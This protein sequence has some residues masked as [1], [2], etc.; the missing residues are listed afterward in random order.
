ME[1][2]DILAGQ[3]G[4]YLLI[5]KLLLQALCIRC[6]GHAFLS[7]DRRHKIIG[8]NVK[9]I[10]RNADAQRELVRNLNLG[11]YNC[12]EFQECIKQPINLRLN[13]LT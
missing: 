12:P 3:T 9:R 10:V 7:N 5:L 13:S 8:R 6:P 4:I 2:Q 1:P 11:E